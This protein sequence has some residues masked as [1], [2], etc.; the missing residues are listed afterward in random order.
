LPHNVTAVDGYLDVCNISD[1]YMGA[2]VDLDLAVSVD[3][4]FGVTVYYEL[5]GFPCGTNNSTQSISVTIPAGQSSSNF[6]ACSS[7]VFFPDGA[8]ICSACIGSCDNPLVNL[9]TFVC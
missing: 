2:A 9:S 1:V 7:G 4:N 8:V 6:N 5:P 3:T